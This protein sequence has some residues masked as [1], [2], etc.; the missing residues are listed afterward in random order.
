MNDLGHQVGK[1]L[2]QKVQVPTLVIHSR[3]DKSVPFSHAEWTLAHISH[4]ELCE[5]GVTG[6]FYWVGPDTQKVCQQLTTFLKAG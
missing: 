3:E 4:A 5:S 6:H 2:L 1:E